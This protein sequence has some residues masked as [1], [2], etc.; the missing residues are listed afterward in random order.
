MFRI[1]NNELPIFNFLQEIGMSIS[2][3]P[4]KKIIFTS[5]HLKL[6]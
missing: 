2:M 3:I 4:V 5:L 1:K 6:N